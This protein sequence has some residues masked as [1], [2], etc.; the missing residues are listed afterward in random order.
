LLQFTLEEQE[1][2]D[3]LHLLQF[4]LEEQEQGDELHLLQFTLVEHLHLSLPLFLHVSHAFLHLQESNPH[5]LQGQLQLVD[6]QSVH[7]VSHLHSSFFLLHTL[8]LPTQLQLPKLQS[9]HLFSH[10]QPPN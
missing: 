1:Q 6:L 3:E 8:H 2:G 10:L 7:L 9:L 4:T 5:P